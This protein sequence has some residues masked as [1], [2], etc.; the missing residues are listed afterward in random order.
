M[1]TV[2]LSITVLA[3]AASLSALLVFPRVAHAASSYYVS[4]TG[5]GMTCS[6]SQPCSVDIG[7]GAAHAGDFVV[8]MDGTYT[9]PL[10]AVHSGTASAWITFIAAQGA[11][12]IFD[13]TE[14][15]MI[16]G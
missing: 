5:S 8:L 3:G 10:R 15:A 12:P 16:D 11:L 7:A 2:R 6:Q 1:S 4:P 13:G 9:S 14:Q